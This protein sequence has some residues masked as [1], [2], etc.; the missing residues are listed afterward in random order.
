MTGHYNHPDHPTWATSHQLSQGLICV[1]LAHG[2]APPHM[3]LLNIIPV[4]WGVIGGP[5][6]QQ[7]DKVT[8]EAGGGYRP[9][10]CTLWSSWMLTKGEV[11][12]KKN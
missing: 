7:I 3:D 6:I 12:E 10:I 9:R 8:G 2:T 4:L 5:L 1:S 11:L